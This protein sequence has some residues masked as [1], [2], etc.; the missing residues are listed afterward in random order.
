MSYVGLLVNCYEIGDADMVSIVIVKISKQL[1][2]EV[3]YYYFKCTENI[4]NEN[5]L[6]SH[7]QGSQIKKK[8]GMGK[9]LYFHLIQY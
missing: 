3:F 4:Q 7:L 8:L 2:C 1:R 6:K 5:E 9:Y